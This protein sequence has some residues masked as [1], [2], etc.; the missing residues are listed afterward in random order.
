MGKT[1]SMHKRV[2]TNSALLVEKRDDPE[3]NRALETLA[4]MKALEA[5]LK[6]KRKL[7]KIV[8]DNGVWQVT[9]GWLEEVLEYLRENG[10]KI[11]K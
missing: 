7:H 2:V 4:R 10:R 6:R 1:M 11:I 5:R 3:R 8:T 9:E